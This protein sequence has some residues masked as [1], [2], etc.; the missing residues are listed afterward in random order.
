MVLSSMSRVIVV[1]DLVR[2][3]GPE[4]CVEK[5]G[6]KDGEGAKSK[7]TKGLMSEQERWI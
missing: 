5:Y 4:V 3:D 6:A 7:E 2:L 1:N